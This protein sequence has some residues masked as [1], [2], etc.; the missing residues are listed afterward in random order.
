MAILATYLIIFAMLLWMGGPT[1]V[2]KFLRGKFLGMTVYVV[3]TIDGNTVA[4]ENPRGQVGHEDF[5]LP[6]FPQETLQ[7]GHFLEY[8]NACWFEYGGLFRCGHS[9]HHAPEDLAHCAVAQKVAGYL[10]GKVWE[11]E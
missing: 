3:L 9:T 6:A 5:P 10:I 11:G 1:L 7:S 8:Y 4:Y 2:K